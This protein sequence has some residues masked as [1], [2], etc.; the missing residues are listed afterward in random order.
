MVKRN[1]QSKLKSKLVSVAIIMVIGLFY[2]IFAKSIFSMFSIEEI[3][4]FVNSFGIWAPLIYI[5]L[6]GLAVVISHIPNIPLAIAAGILFGPVKGGIYTV[7]GGLIGAIICFYLAR[8]IAKDYAVRLLGKNF[9]FCDKCNDTYIAFII[10][11]SR[12]FPIFQFDIISYGAGITN[13]SLKRFI[14]A[15]FFG[16]IPM[17]FILTFY[18]KSLTLSKPLTLILSA[19]FLVAFFVIP[20][21]YKKI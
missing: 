1:K 17:T 16:M 2:F 19:V 3:Q 8:T 21:F 13:I 5:I 9:I 14:T 15:T 6:L 11:F 12:L 18:G 7:I 10:F 4:L 20:F